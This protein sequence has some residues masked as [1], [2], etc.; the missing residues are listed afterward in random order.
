[1]QLLR[2][3]YLVGVVVCCLNCRLALAEGCLKPDFRVII[4]VGHS[5][6]AAGAISARGRPEFNFNLQLATLL[7]ARLKQLGFGKTAKWVTSRPLSL[8]SRVTAENSKNPDLLIS[9]HHDS[10]QSRFLRRGMIDGEPALFSDHARGWSSFVSKLNAHAEESERFAKLVADRLLAAGLT[11]SKHHAEPIPGEGRVFIDETRGIYRYDGLV[12][13]KHSRAPA[14]LF[15][16]GVIVNPAEELELVSAG[17]EIATVEAV[18][19]AVQDFCNGVARTA[20]NPSGATDRPNQK[21][22]QPSTR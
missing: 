15:E 12:V 4:D 3:I 16:T 7:E 6:Q 2:T 11:F 13:L 18:A 20:D 21:L 10:V 5:R 8:D 9:I 14:I 17:R 22:P 19:G 1:M